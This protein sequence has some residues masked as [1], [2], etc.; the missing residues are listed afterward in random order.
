MQNRKLLY[1]EKLPFCEVLCYGMG[2]MAC[3]MVFNFMSSYL[4]YYY[5]DVSGIS[6]GAAGI[7]MSC[8]RLLD[9]FANP[10][11]G[12]CTDKTHSRWGK[13]RPYLLFSALPLALSVV[14]MFL[15]SQVSAGLRTVYAFFTYTL[16]CLLYTVCNVPYSAMMPNISENQQQRN[17]LNMSRF[18]CASMGSLLSM[19]LSIPLVNLFGHGNEQHGFSKLSLLFAFIIVALLLVC[20]ANTRERIQPSPVAFSPKTWKKTIRKSRPWILLCAAQFFHYIALTTRSSSTLYFAK[21]C[22]ADEGFASLLLAVNAF[23]TLAAALIL[24]LL[25][26]KVSKRTISIWGYSLF[27][28]GSLLVYWAGKNHAAV[29]LLNVLANAGISLSAC[30]AT[31]ELADAID[32]SE[33]ATGIRQQGLLTSISMFMV[34]LGGV[35]SSVLSGIVLSLGGYA[36]GRKQTANALL[37]VKINYIFLPCIFGLLCIALFLVY[38]LDREY[39]AVYK[40]LHRQESD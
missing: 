6:A 15:T 4:L 26:A 13:L 17:R 28:A 25:T 29:F 21:Y 30:V 8:A 3:S 40:A 34:K 35:F 39:P 9:A 27:A 14:F 18:V 31:L 20:F 37:A 23:T 36:T 10:A 19:G 5:T 33:Y 12:V 24:P 16:F 32:H 22:L 7:L 11:V 1:K 38:R 2:D